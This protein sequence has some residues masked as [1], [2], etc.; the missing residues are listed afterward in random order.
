[1][2]DRLPDDVWRALLVR[3]GLMPE[4]MPDRPELPA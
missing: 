3:R 1:L 2:L 4:S